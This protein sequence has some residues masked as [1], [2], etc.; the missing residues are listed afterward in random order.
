MRRQRRPPRHEATPGSAHRPRSG[1][2]RPKGPPRDRLVEPSSIPFPAPAGGMIWT[3]RPA[4][5]TSQSGLIARLV[6]A[7]DSL[8]SRC[9]SPPGTAYSITLPSSVATDQAIAIGR[10]GPGPSHAWANRPGPRRDS[11][12]YRRGGPIPA[13]GLPGTT[14]PKATGPGRLAAT[15]SRPPRSLGRP[16][17]LTVAPP[18]SQ[19]RDRPLLSSV[20]TRRPSGRITTRS[21]APSWRGRAWDGL[22]AVSFKVVEEDVSLAAAGDEQLAVAT[23]GKAPDAIGHHR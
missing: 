6:T 21:I 19:T 18:A 15:S 12:G 10:R 1:G 17:S 5:A 20:T 23:D 22:E 16:N 11:R 9:F 8:C 13:P 14:S 4:A 7:P 3:E 2:H